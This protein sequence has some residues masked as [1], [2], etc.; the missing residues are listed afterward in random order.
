M[1]DLRRKEVELIAAVGNLLTL[2]VS[3][4]ELG[5]EVIHVCEWNRGRLG[6]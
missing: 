5:C 1:P 4:D 6:L 2:V 3:P